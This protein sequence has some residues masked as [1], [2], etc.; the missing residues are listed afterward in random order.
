MSSGSYYYDP[1]TN[2]K[3]D[4]SNV[5]YYKQLF[6]TNSMSRYIDRGLKKQMI[7]SMNLDL[8]IMEL[9]IQSRITEKINNKLST[10]TDVLCNQLSQLQLEYEE[11]KNMLND[12]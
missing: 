3:V 5:N 10:E 1:E 8:Q 7:D 2:W 12:E 4:W 9:S 11:I 6:K